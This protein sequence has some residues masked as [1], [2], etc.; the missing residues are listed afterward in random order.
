VKSLDA[1]SMYDK[2]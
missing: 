1:V 2:R